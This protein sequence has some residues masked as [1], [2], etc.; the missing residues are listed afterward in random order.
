MHTRRRRGRPAAARRRR[1]TGAEGVVVL[2]LRDPPAADLPGL[3]SPARTSTSCSRPGWSG[4]TRCA[5][6]RPT[7]GAGGSRVLREPA[8]RG[9]SA[10]VHEQLH[11]GDDGR[12]ARAA[13]PLPAASRRPRYLFVAGGIGI[14][15]ILP[16]IAAAEAAGAEW[17]LLYGGRTPALDGLRAR[18]WRPRTATGST[19]HPQDEVGLLDL[20]RLLG[21]P[22]RGHPRL[23]LRARAA[24]ATPSSSAA[25]P[26][27]RLAARRAVRAQG[28]RRA[29]ADRAP[30]RSSWPPTGLTLTVPPEQSVWRWSRRP[31]VAVLSSCGGNVRH[32]RDGRARG[33]V[34]PPRL[35]ADPGGAGGRTTRCSSACP[36][37]RARGWC[38]TSERGRAR[39]G[40]KRSPSSAPSPGTPRRSRS[41][42]LARLAGVPLSTAHRLVAELSAWGGAGAG[43]R[44][45]LPHRPAAVGARRARAA[46]ARPARGRAAVHGGPVRG[47][48]RERAAGRAGRRRGRVRR[49]LRRRGTRCRCSPRSAAG[50]PCRHRRRAGAARPRAGRGAGAGARRARCRLHAVRSPTRGS[51]AGCSPRSAP[52][53]AVSDRQVTVDAVSVAAPVL[54]G[55]RRRRALD[56]RPRDLARRRP[57]VDPRRRRGP[58][59]LPT[60]DSDDDNGPPRLPAPQRR[61]ETRLRASGLRH[62][63]RPEDRSHAVGRRRRHGT[64]RGRRLAGQG[65]DRRWSD[66]A[67][68]RTAPSSRPPATRSAR[69]ARPR[70]RTCTPPPSARSRHRRPGR[71]CPSRSGPPCCAGPATC[72]R[73]TA[74]EIKGWLARESGAIQPF[75]DFQVHTSAQECYE[76]V[77][78]AS[79]PVRRAAAH[80]VAAAVV[81]PPHTGRRGRA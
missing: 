10:H 79:P 35:A 67:A 2:D 76:A 27:R 70:P 30:S 73:R 5:A 78:A 59:H 33:R 21:A 12:G 8:G 72:W 43:R 46:R 60:L 20:D 64:A 66:G 57:R 45:P 38:W 29:G 44:R 75:G 52:G 14:T 7:G 65:L 25:P 69:S 50:S 47:H 61:P 9:G 4:S 11:E 36:A 6:T 42:E 77:G 16:M 63:R 32:V 28:R 22:A 49:A 40:G 26:G 58:G 18:R 53:V 48:P 23:L 68:A 81:R 74:D 1:T 71:R 3:G 19:L 17:A 31:G 54:A 62:R 55:D 41:R 34:G 39:P 56:G 13:Q 51:C 80:R 37:R 24:A 15:P